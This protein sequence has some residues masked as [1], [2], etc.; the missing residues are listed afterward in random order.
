MV[1]VMNR[2]SVGFSMINGVGEHGNILVF[3]QQQ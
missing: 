1:G 2:R 3:E